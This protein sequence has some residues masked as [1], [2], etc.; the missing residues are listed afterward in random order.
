MTDLDTRATT[1]LRRHLVAKLAFL[2]GGT[3]SLFLSVF[4][5]FV[6]DEPEQGIFVGLWVPS[7]FSLG[8]LVLAG[9]ERDG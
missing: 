7:L 6:A 2:A 9:G 8:A 4:L 3:V 1:P 5:F